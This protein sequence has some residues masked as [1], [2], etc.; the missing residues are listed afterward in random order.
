M[1]RATD[2]MQGS[3]LSPILDGGNVCPV[4]PAFT[5]GKYR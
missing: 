2:R 1:S 4:G 3:L 5:F